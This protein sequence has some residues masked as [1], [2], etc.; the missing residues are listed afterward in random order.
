MENVTTKEKKHE[1]K[2]Q[3]LAFLLSAGVIAKSISL[4][5]SSYAD[6]SNNAGCP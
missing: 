6:T 1:K 2:K 5:I 3:S 4:P